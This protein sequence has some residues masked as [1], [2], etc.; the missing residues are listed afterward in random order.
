MKNI[1]MKIEI[2]KD[3][4]FLHSCSVNI[5][6]EDFLFPLS[7]TKK[8]PSMIQCNMKE[9]VAD[10]FLC[11]PQYLLLHGYGDDEQLVGTP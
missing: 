4:K 6:Y 1:H 9:G 11:S 7:Q 3:F 5:I 8:I 2:H 10:L